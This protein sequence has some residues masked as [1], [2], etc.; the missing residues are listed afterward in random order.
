MPSDDKS[1]KA[2]A[3]EKNSAAPSQ[4]GDPVSLKPETVE[5][6]PTEQDKPNKAPNKIDQQGKSLKQMAQDKMETNPSQIGDPVSLKAETS[7]NEPTE[8][9]RGALGTGRDEKTGRPVKSKIRRPTT[10]RRTDNLQY[11]EDI[12][13]TRIEGS[14]DETHETGSDNDESPTPTSPKD[15][16]TSKRQIRPSKKRK[17]STSKPAQEEKDSQDTDDAVS[18]GDSVRASVDSQITE[19]ATERLLQRQTVPRSQQ[20]RVGRRGRRGRMTGNM[21]A[22]T[23]FD[24]LPTSPAHELQ[25]IIIQTLDPPIESGA[26]TETDAYILAFELADD[27]ARDVAGNNAMGIIQGQG[28]PAGLAI[29]STS[30]NKP[31]RPTGNQLSVNNGGDGQDRG[32]GHVDDAAAEVDVVFDEDPGYAADAEE[33]KQSTDAIAPPATGRGDRGFQKKSMNDEVQNDSRALVH[34]QTPRRGRPRKVESLAKGLGHATSASEGSPAGSHH[35]AR[36]EK[37]R[38]EA[39]ERERRELQRLA[40]RPKTRGF[41]QGY[42]GFSAKISQPKEK[43]KE[44]VAVKSKRNKMTARQATLHTKAKKKGTA[45][46]M[47]KPKAKQSKRLNWKGE[48]MQLVRGQGHV[49]VPRG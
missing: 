22:H 43:G 16:K 20:S 34:D 14:F 19:A 26:L 13:G 15:G 11:Y 36:A 29:T 24:E 5:H 44:V 35:N 48:Q 3:R 32:D 17:L 27:D 38:V 18:T 10:I 47:G 28:P 30:I 25:D 33:V 31:T 40:A 41:Q 23:S 1:L 7:H 6:S 46:R 8:Q 39:L 45:K 42:N 12:Y 4:L 37:K 21:A 49:V 2:I 9:D